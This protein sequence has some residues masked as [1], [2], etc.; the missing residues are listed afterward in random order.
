MLRPCYI[1]CQVKHP[2][3]RWLINVINRV[4]FTCD[5]PSKAC[6][7][8]SWLR[9]EPL[10]AVTTLWQFILQ[11]PVQSSM[12]TST[13]S[14]GLTCPGMEEQLCIQ[15]DSQ[16][17][18]DSPR[19]SSLPSTQQGCPCVRNRRSFSSTVREPGMPFITFYSALGENLRPLLSPKCINLGAQNLIFVFSNDYF[20][21]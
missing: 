9:T 16:S 11:A 13:F 15:R 3:T 4:A 12:L 2:R 1:S 19:A 14:S 8:G 18:D 10:Y 5:I 6:T 21:M 20:R 7:K 17:H